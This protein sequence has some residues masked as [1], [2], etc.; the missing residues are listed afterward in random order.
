[1]TPE[2]M[3]EMWQRVNERLDLTRVVMGDIAA[4]WHDIAR[5]VGLGPDA[6]SDDTIDAEIVEVEEE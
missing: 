6:P 1:M 4:R 2:E 3:T 5:T